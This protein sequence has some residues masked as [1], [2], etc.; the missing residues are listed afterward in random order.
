MGKPA[1]LLERAPKASAAKDIGFVFDTTV[2]EGGKAIK[3]AIAPYPDS[4]AKFVWDPAAKSWDVWL[5]KKPARA[6]EGGTQHATTV[7][8]QYV[9]QYD[10]GYHDKYSGHTPML[11]SVGTGKGVVLRDGKAWPVTWSRPVA[12]GGTTYTLADGQR[13]TFAPGQVW[14]VLV[15]NKSKV[16]LG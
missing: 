3:Q 7:V 9:R 2:P 14:V 12:T 10:S 5:N 11:V 1:L 15:N 8:F 6:T 16:S 4:Q 13:M